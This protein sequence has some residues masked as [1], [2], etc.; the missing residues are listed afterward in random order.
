M[1]T[2]RLLALCWTCDSISPLAEGA[3]SALCALRSCQG[4]PVEPRFLARQTQ[5]GARQRPLPRGVYDLESHRHSQVFR[6]HEVL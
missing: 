4:L 1:G 2:C 5:Q 6:W 3:A